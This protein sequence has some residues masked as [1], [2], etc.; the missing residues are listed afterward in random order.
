MK[1]LTAI[2][3]TTLLLSAPTFATQDAAAIARKYFD[4]K[5]PEDTQARARMVLQDR[6]G[7]ERE[8]V[9][10]ILTRRNEAGTHTYMEFEA[11][12]DV[13]GTRFLTTPRADQ[14]DEQRI[15]LPAL[16]RSRLIAAS[17]K[18][19]RFVGSDFYYYDLEDRSFD[20]SKYTYVREESIDDQIYDVI[21]MKPVSDNSPYRVV[22]AWVSRKDN[23]VYR[24]DLFEGSGDSP[25]K[26]MQVHTTK[27]QDGII[28]P[29]KITMTSSNPKHTTTMVL[30]DLK[31]NSGV[32]ESIFT[33]RHLERR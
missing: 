31:I 27:I 32:E 6:N 21:A 19:G 3:C 33:P 5:K 4:L 10:D 23:F 12:A 22:W 15:Y 20:D 16:R 30:E 17:G 11:P 13:R 29:T 18:N 25:A 2:L 26:Q 28:V 14:D 9:L 8:R 7:N 1:T 24:M